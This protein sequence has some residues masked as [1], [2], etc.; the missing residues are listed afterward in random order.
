M[1]DGW[2]NRYMHP[3]VVASLVGCCVSDTTSLDSDLGSGWE[4]FEG[5]SGYTYI[6][7]HILHHV[8][9]EPNNLR[10]WVYVVMRYEHTVFRSRFVRF[11]R[12]YEGFCVVFE[13]FVV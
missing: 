9:Y 3:F 12:A 4:I 13:C 8:W 6:Y 2:M 10:R 7:I 11:L 5:T 1:M